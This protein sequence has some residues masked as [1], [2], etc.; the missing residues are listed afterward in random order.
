MNNRYIVEILSN[1]YDHLEYNTVTRFLVTH[2]DY[3][4]E[5]ISVNE[6]TKLTK[7]YT[8]FHPGN[9]AITINDITC[10]ILHP[11]KNVMIN[12]LDEYTP[13]KPLV[14]YNILK[15]NIEHIYLEKFDK[16]FLYGTKNL[17]ETRVYKD[18]EEIENS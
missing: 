4:K 10:A 16:M 8:I 15:F 17:K 3:I 5:N 18:V 1:E 2:I 7:L 14:A 13:N 12:G 9:V 11:D 6:L